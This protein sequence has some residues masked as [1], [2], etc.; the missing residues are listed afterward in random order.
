MPNRAPRPAPRRGRLTWAYRIDLS[1]LDPTEA[2]SAILALP[3]YAR[4]GHPR[5]LDLVVGHAHPD[6]PQLVRAGTVAEL[7]KAIDGGVVDVHLIGQ[8]RTVAAWW[9]ELSE[10]QPTRHLQVV[11]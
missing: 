6:D 7:A 11:Q 9:R 3:T 4:D 10:P 8:P 1:E 2:F 5:P